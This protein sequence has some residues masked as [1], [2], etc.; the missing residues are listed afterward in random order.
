LC[1][2]QRRL[3]HANVLTCDRPAVPEPIGPGSGNYRRTCHDRD[4]SA[5]FCAVDPPLLRFLKPFSTPRHTS[6]VWIVPKRP[7]FRIS[8]SQARLKTVLLD[9]ADVLGRVVRDVSSHD[10]DLAFP[11]V[12]DQ[13]SRGC[14]RRTRSLTLAIDPAMSSDAALIRVVLATSRHAPSRPSSARCS[15]TRS[16]LLSHAALPGRTFF[17]FPPSSFRPAALLGSITRPFAGLLPRMGEPSP[18]L[19]LGPTC[20][21]ARRAFAPRFIFVGVTPR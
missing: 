18:F 9:T 16:G 12:C 10:V 7:S 19:V 13:K 20:R 11:I 15:A 3:S 14:D 6:R 17:E 1:D 21:F 5:R 2:P 4:R 8:R